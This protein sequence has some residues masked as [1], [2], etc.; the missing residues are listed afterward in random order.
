MVDNSNGASRM[1]YIDVATKASF[2]YHSE[3]SGFTGVD[4]SPSGLMAYTTGG[5]VQTLSSP[6]QRPT[7]FEPT[8]SPSPQPS[9]EPTLRPTSRPSAYT[10]VL[11]ESGNITVPEKNGSEEYLGAS[12]A[13]NGN[14]FMSAS[15]SGSGS[16]SSLYY[17]SQSK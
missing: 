14:I 4:V 3:P 7:T 15:S 11:Y 13:V 2:T 6:T 1:R 12:V 8:L 17:M 10:D 5:S 9:E 16:L